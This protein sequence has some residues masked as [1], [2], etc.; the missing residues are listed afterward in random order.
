[1]PRRDTTD[2]KQRLV[3]AI[4][5]G[6]TVEEACRSVGK[7]MQTY[8]YYRRTDKEFKDKVDLIRTATNK[9]LSTDSV[10]KQISFAE[11]RQ[12]YLGS[13]TFPHQQNIVDLLDGDQPQF[14]HPS[15]LWE[16]GENP[17]YVLVNM[18]PE[19]A[20]SMTIS[21]DYVT[22][23]VALNPNIRVKIVSKN[24]DLA[25]HFL[26]AIKQRLTHPNYSD[27]QVTYAPGVGF[28]S[29]SA[30]WREDQIFLGQELRDSNEA[31]PTIQALGM[32]GHIYGTRADLMILDD[33][34]T[35]SNAHEYEKQIRWI[36]QEVITRLGPGGKILILGTRVDAKDLYRELRNPERYQ[37]GEPPWTYLAMPALLEPKDD[38]E[39]WVTL[40][41]KSDEP[42]PG[43]KD[44]QPDEEGLYVRWDG[45]RLR[46]RRSAMDPRT[47]NMVYQ[48]ADVD[49]DSI[50]APAAVKGSVDRM[51]M[52]GVLAPGGPGHPESTE[53]F[54]IVAGLD[55]AIVGYTAAVVMA[56][57]RKG[58]K[59]W[60]LD[61][62]AMLGP[63]PA[64]IRE[65]IQTWTTKYHPQEWMVERNA[66]QGYLTQDENLRSWLASQ[67]V[68]LRE[69]TTSKNKWDAGFGVAAM[70]PLFGTVQSDG[71]HHRDNLIH[72]P[73]DR[74]EPVRML[75]D[76]LITWSPT[77]KG[78]TD[79]VMA[80]WFCEIRA[81][82]LLQHSMGV[83][84]YM[85]NGYLS[86]N[87]QSKRVVVNLDEV[88]NTPQRI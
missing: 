27:L 81:R 44:Q 26:G 24:M 68:F 72:L 48:Q 13:R 59:R 39:D 73:A 78:K 65:L 45:P 69:H 25:K 19:H 64:Q 87:E 74:S 18:P 14:L 8:D 35:L 79:L 57:D 52:P 47:W 61:C 40:W 75:I 83:K 86:R 46:R 38:P 56:V 12:K 15:M 55:P 20:K 63:S 53:G 76:Q 50:F 7:S 22:Y 71:K 66:F 17:D 4:Q 42:W 2:T 9:S 60:I 70:A 23:R 30:V 54:Y 16:Q 34:V 28:K 29:K 6:Y 1:M 36:Q 82:E 33:T 21:I 3:N 37:E 32:G 62:A 80:L 10:E 43:L 11:F 31:D 88:L 49:E 5:N 84:H 77:T 41:P 51:R 85:N 58:H 67:G